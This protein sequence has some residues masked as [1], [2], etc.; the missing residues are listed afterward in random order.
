MWSILYTP[1]CLNVPV[2]YK[3]SHLWVDLIGESDGSTETFTETDEKRIIYLRSL[4][5]KSLPPP[6]S[7]IVD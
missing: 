4:C 5:L 3:E 6:S 1:L 2:N 7:P